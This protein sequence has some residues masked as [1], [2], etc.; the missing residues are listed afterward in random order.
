MNNKARLVVW[1]TLFTSFFVSGCNSYYEWR[2]DTLLETIGS[3]IKS[4]DFEQFYDEFSETAKRYSYSKGEFIVRMNIVTERM[5]N[6]DDSLTMRKSTG[7]PNIDTFWFPPSQ[8]TYRYVEKNGKRLGIN[9]YF[10]SGKLLDFCVHTEKDG[11]NENPPS[12]GF[13]MSDASKS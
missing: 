6:V 4:G 10:Y 1:I 7:K 11:V 2:N 5:R 13:C 8:Y 12:D 3:Q 9:I